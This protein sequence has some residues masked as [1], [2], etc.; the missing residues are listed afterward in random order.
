[1]SRTKKILGIKNPVILGGIVKHS[2]G[3]GFK[4]T[5]KNR[6]TANKYKDMIRWI[7][8][9]DGF[10]LVYNVGYY[11]DYKQDGLKK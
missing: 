1:M 9:D 2:K 4:T 6:E 7:L 8:A 5:F 3:I 10:S 11:D